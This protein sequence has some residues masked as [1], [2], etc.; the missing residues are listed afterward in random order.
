MKETLLKHL[1]LPLFVASLTFTLGISAASILRHASS[2]PREVAITRPSREYV[3]GNHYDAARGA[4][5]EFTSSDGEAFKKWT[6]TCGSPQ[7]A[8]RRMEELLIKAERVITREP[9][10]DVA[11]H[12]VGEEVVAVFTANDT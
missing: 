11:G 8:T 12:P 4:L 5:M 9:V 7:G 10:F 3:A 2:K 1:G 6:I